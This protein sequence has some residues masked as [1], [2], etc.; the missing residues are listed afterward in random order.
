MGEVKKN[1]SNFKRSLL[2]WLNKNTWVC[3]YLC[4]QA[5][6]YFLIK[7]A[8]FTPGRF[9]RS[10]LI[11]KSKIGFCCHMIWLFSIHL[12][13]WNV[14]ILNHWKSLL[15]RPT[16]NGCIQWWQNLPLLPGYVHTDGTQIS[17]GFWTQWTAWMK[18]I[19]VIQNDMTTHSLSQICIYLFVLITTNKE[20]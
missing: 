17:A 20:M 3:Y 18:Y 2:L 9:I 13:K 5:N 11:E 15:W 1:A 10:N 6:Q 8:G 19:R 4:Y 14:E 16:C 7:D 12:R